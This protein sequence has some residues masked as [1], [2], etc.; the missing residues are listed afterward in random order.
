MIK[1]FLRIGSLGVI[2]AIAM[3]SCSDEQQFVDYNAQAKKVEVQVL[4]S[5][6][7]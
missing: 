3:T 5:E 2:A 4:T 6:L 1:N 7:A